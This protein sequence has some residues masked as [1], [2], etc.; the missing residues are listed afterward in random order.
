MYHIQSHAQV[1]LNA[2]NFFSNEL[3]RMKSSAEQDP[4]LFVAHQEK[5][6]AGSV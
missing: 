1:P 2:I 5:I 3:P 4:D 6:N